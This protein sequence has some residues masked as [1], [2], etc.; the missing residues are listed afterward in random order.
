MQKNK[1]ILIVE[2]DYILAYNLKRDVESFGFDIPAISSNSEE[3]IK[4]T[5]KI[6]PDMI[7][8]D[9]NLGNGNDGI[10]TASIIRTSKD[11]PILFLTAYSD[12]NTLD[13][14]KITDPS[15]YIIKPWNM[16]ELESNNKIALYKIEIEKKLKDTQQFLECVLTSVGDGVI[17]T[18]MNEKIKFINPI[19]EAITGW[20]RSDAVGKKLKTV[21][22]LEEEKNTEY[23]DEWKVKVIELGINDASILLKK[24][25]NKISVSMN[26][27][28][29]KDKENKVYGLVI[30]LRDISDKITSM[31]KKDA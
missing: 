16:K 7:I 17:A 11:I 5:S 20:Y 12:E 30:T 4:M 8:M 25:G 22:S 6:N 27:N 18:D 10:E 15:A 19:A 31:E 26:T 23:N 14:T 2:E 21:L 13:R 28:L 29:I 9:I 24:N 3:A 1:K